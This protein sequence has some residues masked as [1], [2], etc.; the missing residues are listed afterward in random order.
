MKE[1]K[2]IVCVKQIPD[3]EA[4]SE[5][6][7]IDSE[8]KKVTLI[9]PPPNVISPFDENAIEAALQI[10]DEN[11]AEVTVLS[12]GEKISPSVLRKGL[13]VGADNLILVED[14]NFEDLESYS[15]AYVLAN[16][17]EKIG[18][19]DLILTGRQAGDWD[20]GQVGL[21]LGEM[22]GIVTVNLA[23]R[24]RIEDGK[25]VV[26][27][28]MPG[29]FELINAEMPALVTVSNEVG[30]LRYP[31][32]KNILLSR[33]QPIDVWDAE[34]IDIEFEKLN[35]REIVE[36]IPPPDIRRQCQFIEGD[37]GEEKGEKLAITLKKAILNS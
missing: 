2:I 11:G 16:A 3:P 33:R 24:V 10:K 6:V 26:E 5:V 7:R 20:S 17:I 21:I 4:P 36:L 18:D 15:I 23:R 8:R 34:S 29:G 30:E 31:S 32:M 25:L 14:Q 19:Y 9:G 35:K 37:S 27:K 22:L 28:I 1:V 13:A 12:I